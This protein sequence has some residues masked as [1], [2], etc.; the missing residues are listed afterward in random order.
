MLF[1]CLTSAAQLGFGLL[2]LASVAGGAPRRK[3]LG[4]ERALS[5]WSGSA[6]FLRGRKDQLRLII[7]REGPEASGEHFYLESLVNAM[8]TCHC[9][10]TAPVDHRKGRHK[11]HI[12]N[13]L[14]GVRVA[15]HHT[16]TSATLRH[17]TDWERCR[18][19]GRVPEHPSTW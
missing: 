13:L 17:I 11:E 5:V 9:P 16:R 8:N 6:Q 1:S 10:A 7:R 12:L 2:Q 18:G 14:P 3:V 4:Q 19:P 15:S